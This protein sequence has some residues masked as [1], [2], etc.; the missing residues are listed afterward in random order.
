MVTVVTA[1][2]S[3]AAPLQQVHS[4]TVAS[5]I[6]PLNQ[7]PRVL[8][9]A[10]FDT[11]QPKPAPLNVAKQPEFVV[12]QLANPKRP[13]PA[14]PPVHSNTDCIS[15]GSDAPVVPRIMSLKDAEKMLTPGMVA[16]VPNLSLWSLL[17]DDYRKCIIMDCTKCAMYVFPVV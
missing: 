6:E 7:V 12:P 17:P 9:H 15:N 16:K 2:P 11:I 3:M 10:V 8:P 13:M 4:H 14:I 5:T 1:E